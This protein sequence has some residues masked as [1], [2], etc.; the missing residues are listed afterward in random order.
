[1]GTNDLA[2]IVTLLQTQNQLLEGILVVASLSLGSLLFVHFG[3]FMR[4]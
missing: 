1:M 3:R 2:E 4:W